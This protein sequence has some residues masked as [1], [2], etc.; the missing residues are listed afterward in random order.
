MLPCTKTDDTT[1]P[2][3]YGAE[4]G[5]GEDLSFSV[6]YR[7][8]IAPNVT[9][10]TV[11]AALAFNASTTK[12]T[13]YT[14]AETANHFIAPLTIDAAG[15][16]ILNATSSTLTNNAISK[17]VNTSSETVVT[18]VVSNYTGE[19][20]NSTYTAFTV[21][22]TFTY[23]WGSRFN[24]L[25]PAEYATNENLSTVVSDLATLQNASGAAL[26]V[27]LATQNA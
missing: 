2:I 8:E 16:T 22:T 11:T 17:T 19:K 23:Y 24:Y 5:G 20:T 14:T 26:K 13:A 25:N 6:T 21:T 4:S 3:V 9:T 1:G 27:T 15:S 7:V 18:S 12:E 10:G